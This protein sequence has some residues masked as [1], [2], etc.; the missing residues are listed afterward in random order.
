[1]SFLEEFSKT[2]STISG[3]SQTPILL[4]TYSVI[5]I[6]IIESM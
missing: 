1:M 2:L 6:I 4:I 5:A 3:I